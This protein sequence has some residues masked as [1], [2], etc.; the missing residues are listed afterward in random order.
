[1]ITAD[2]DNFES[3]MDRAEEHGKRWCL[4][5]RKPATTERLRVGARAFYDPTIT[6]DAGPPAGERGRQ[7]LN[8][9]GKVSLKRVWA[10]GVCS[11]LLPTMSSRFSGILAPAVRLTCR[12]S[13]HTA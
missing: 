2:D 5:A 13:H 10:A 9:F 8:A 1:M 7:L 6:L 12:P 3:E 4:A 11:A